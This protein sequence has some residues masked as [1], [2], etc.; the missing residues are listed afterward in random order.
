MPTN[1]IVHILEQIRALAFQNISHFIA[2]LLSIDTPELQVY[3]EE[4]KTQECTQL[5]LEALSL[6]GSCKTVMS[7]AVE[8]SCTLFKHEVLRASNVESGLH[9]NALNARSTN[10]LN[11]DLMKIAH[12]FK[13]TAPSLWGV[14]QMLLD[15]NK[16]AHQWKV[17]V[18]ATSYDRH[19][20]LVD[21]LNDNMAHEV[22]S[23]DDESCDEMEGEEWQHE[24][25]QKG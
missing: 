14:V 8:Q 12:T 5:I 11:F 15:A 24:Q 25:S 19:H 10:I 3:T 9:F 23:D 1:P 20:E 21:D 7:W 6:Y 16:T 22:K 2:H 4:L 13:H 17:P 18:G